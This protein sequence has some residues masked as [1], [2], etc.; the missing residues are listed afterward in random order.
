MNWV[1][2]SKRKLDF[3]YLLEVNDKAKER[4]SK[5]SCFLHENGLVLKTDLMREGSEIIGARFSILFDPAGN[6]KVE[7]EEM[8]EI[9][10]KET[11]MENLTVD[12]FDLIM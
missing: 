2:G 5:L 6:S 3:D 8:L 9:F 10:T 11:T 7:P 12:E 1:S 4:L